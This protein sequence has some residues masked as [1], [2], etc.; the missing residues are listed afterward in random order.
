VSDAV[1]I[2]SWIVPS[3]V[4]GFVIGRWW[5]AALAPAAAA[6]LL[7]GYAFNPCVPGGGVECDLNVPALVLAYFMPPAAV[8][9]VLGVGMRRGMRILRR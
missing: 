3:V 8:L 2:A 1:A 5:A 7:V 6:A 4:A 9:L